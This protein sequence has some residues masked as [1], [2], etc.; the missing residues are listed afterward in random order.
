M[1]PGTGAG[2]AE[3][4]HCL[5]TIHQRSQNSQSNS[6][7]TGTRQIY[8]PVAD[9]ALGFASDYNSC[10]SA[11]S[12]GCGVFSLQGTVLCNGDFLQSPQIPSPGNL[13]FPGIS[14]GYF[15]L[16]LWRFLVSQCSH[17]FITCGCKA[18][19]IRHNL[20]SCI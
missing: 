7:S 5:L 4:A 14:H 1:T 15:W 11:I 19:R 13:F 8:R 17:F 12:R 9:T 6:D 10:H 3:R 18:C 20:T 2:A 16:S